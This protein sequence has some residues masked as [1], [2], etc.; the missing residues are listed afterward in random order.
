VVLDSMRAAVGDAVRCFLEAFVPAQRRRVAREYARRCAEVGREAAESAETV[1]QQAAELLPFEPP[2]V[3]PPFRTVL[4]ALG[5]SA[6]ETAMAVESVLERA[7]YLA[8]SLEAGRQAAAG[9]EA[10]GAEIHELL[11]LLDRVSREGVSREGAL[12][13]DGAQP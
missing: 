1:W 5:Q 3:E 4:A 13:G 7:A 12:A 8:T 11:T 10:R 2:Q 6:R 9:H